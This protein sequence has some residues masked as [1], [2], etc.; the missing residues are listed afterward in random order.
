MTPQEIKK[1]HERLKKDCKG[2]RLKL[3]NDICMKL[4]QGCQKPKL[5]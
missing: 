4:Y 5:N 3:L 2:L 1:S